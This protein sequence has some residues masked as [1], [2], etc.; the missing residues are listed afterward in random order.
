MTASLI[1]RGARQWNP[2]KELKAKESCDCRTSTTRNVESGEGIERKNT[3]P[4]DNIK[5]RTVESGEGIES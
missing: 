5:T 2:V 4:G 3:H 1:E